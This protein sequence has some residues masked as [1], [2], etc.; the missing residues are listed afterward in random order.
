L[1]ADLLRIGTNLLVR[2]PFEQFLGGLITP[3][4]GGGGSA[5][6]GLLGGIGS[7]FTSIFGSIF[8][9]GGM[10]GGVAPQRAVPAIAFAGAPR[11]HSGGFPGLRSDEVP[12]ILQ[13]GER[14]LSREEVRR[15]GGG[16]GQV[17]VTIVAPSPDSFSASRA[18]IEG[19]MARAVR[20]GARNT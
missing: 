3:G 8:H 6:G 1:Q 12:A 17:N 16:G 5:A 15:G 10:V 7:L 19:R 14:V 4:Q 2:Q 9:D 18:L 11:F 20:M 13:R